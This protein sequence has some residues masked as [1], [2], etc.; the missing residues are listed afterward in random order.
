MFLKW[1]TCAGLFFAFLFWLNL[2]FKFSNSTILFYLTTISSA[3]AT[4]NAAWQLAN[5]KQLK[6]LF[7]YSTLVLSLLNIMAAL[8]AVYLFDSSN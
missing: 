7:A 1:Y 5:P 6:W 8:L 3:I 2:D 4:I